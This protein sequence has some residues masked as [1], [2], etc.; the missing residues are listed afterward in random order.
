MVNSILD[1]DEEYVC[2]SHMQKIPCSLGDHHLISNWPTDV[3][4]VLDRIQQ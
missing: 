1:G 2:I 4:K 3:A